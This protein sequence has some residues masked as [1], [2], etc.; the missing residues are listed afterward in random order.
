MQYTFGRK[1]SSGALPR[2][3]TAGSLNSQKKKT[4][5]SSICQRDHCFYTAVIFSWYPC[6]SSV[7]YRKY[8]SLPLL[9]SPATRTGPVKTGGR[10]F[11]LEHKRRAHLQLA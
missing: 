1:R 8:I 10:V 4:A 5:F 6:R 11:V 3:G 2:F 7:R 9:A